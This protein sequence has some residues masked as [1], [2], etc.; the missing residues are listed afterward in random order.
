MHAGTKPVSSDLISMHSVVSCSE[1]ATTSRPVTK[2][3][4]HLPKASPI[5]HIGFFFFF[6]P[7]N[8]LQGLTGEIV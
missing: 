5:T 3:I 6:F 4:H 8:S 2:S 1:S 7:T